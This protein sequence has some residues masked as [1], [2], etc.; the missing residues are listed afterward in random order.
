[1]AE[2][3][4]HHPPAGG[5]ALRRP[6]LPRQLAAL[7]PDG[8][9]RPRRRPGLR[10]GDRQGRARRR[11][12]GGAEHRVPRHRA[13]ALGAREVPSLA[14]GR[15]PRPRPRRRDRE[16]LRAHPRAGRRRRHDHGD[17]LR[18]PRARAGRGGGPRGPRPDPPRG[19]RPDVQRPAARPA[20]ERLGPRL[21]VRRPPP[22][23]DGR[24]CGAARPPRRAARQPLDPRR[25][26]PGAGT[27]GARGPGRAPPG[28][29]RRGPAHPLAALPART[30]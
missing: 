26:E 16:P 5:P 28:R 24:G 27:L 21:G 11:A 12:H 19:R 15:A 10:R 13:R 18:G 2:V 30:P 25:R 20:R 29:P 22:P 9:L 7:P 14:R 8:R 23:P 4:R 1:M 3:R 17:V 6:V